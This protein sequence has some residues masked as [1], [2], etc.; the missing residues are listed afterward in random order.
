MLFERIPRAAVFQHVS[1]LEFYRKIDRGPG[2]SIDIGCRDHMAQQ[3]PILAVRSGHL[4]AI[5]YVPKYGQD[6]SGRETFTE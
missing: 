3:K 2:C 5:I 1:V 4:Q 6:K